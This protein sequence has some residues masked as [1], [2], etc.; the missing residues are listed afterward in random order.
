MPPSQRLALPV[1]ASRLPGKVRDGAPRAVLGQPFAPG[2]GA[3]WQQVGQQAVCSAFVHQRKATI[4]CLGVDLLVQVWPQ[5]FAV[6]GRR[7]VVCPRHAVFEFGKCT[8]QE[9]VDG[10]G[11]QGPDVVGVVVGTVGAQGAA[12]ELMANSLQP[13]RASYVG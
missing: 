6:R 5:T 9:P 7:S 1:I 13:I 2:H 4:G 3:K 8:G 10:R 12:C 11:L